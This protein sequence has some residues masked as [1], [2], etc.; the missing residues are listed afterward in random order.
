M[1]TPYGAATVVQVFGRYFAAMLDVQVQTAEPT[2]ALLRVR[3]S[4]LLT[5]GA[6][7][8]VA[9]M[10]ATIVQPPESATVPP[11]VVFRT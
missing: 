1:E 4:V 7:T 5:R 11:V 8:P 3:V 6:A 2:S 10:V 9:C